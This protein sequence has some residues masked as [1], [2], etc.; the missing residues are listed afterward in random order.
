MF[1]LVNGLLVT[2]EPFAHRTITY[3]FQP[4]LKV[5]LTLPFQH[6]Q[7]YKSLNQDVY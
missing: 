6:L 1:L 2:R 7:P 5:G 3:D 4:L